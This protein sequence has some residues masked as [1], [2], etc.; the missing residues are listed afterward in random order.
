[1]IYSVHFLDIALQDK[2]C[3]AVWQQNFKCLFF[4]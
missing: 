4:Y 2:R 1:V 3:C